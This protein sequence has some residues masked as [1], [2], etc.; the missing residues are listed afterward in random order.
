MRIGGGVMA[1]WIRLGGVVG[2]A[3]LALGLAAVPV[4][5]AGSRSLVEQV[6]YR[7]RDG[8]DRY[9]RGGQYDRGDRGG[10]YDRGGRYDRG[11]PYDRGDRGDRRGGDGGRA[12]GGTYL[13]SCSD[14]RLQG[15]TLQAI[16]RG[17]RGRRFETSI[18]VN[19]C[20][21]DIGNQFGTLTCQGVQGR[22]RRAE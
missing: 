19:R 14:V 10:Q 6:Q 18:D 22:S 3:L 21:G 13:Q 5:A 15:S 1:I 9:D 4:W 17:D 16:C 12:P 2:G 11:G 8:G 20:R 7:D